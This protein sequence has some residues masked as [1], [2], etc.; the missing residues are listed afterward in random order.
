MI[1][2]GRNVHPTQAVKPIDLMRW[3]V[4]MVVPPDGVVLDPFLGSGSTGCAAVMEDR[5]F[6]GIEREAEYARIA[7]ARIKYWWSQPRQLELG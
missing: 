7:E 2:G 5:E 4:R 6:I 1:G 3:L